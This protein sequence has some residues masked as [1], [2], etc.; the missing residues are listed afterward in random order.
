MIIPLLWLSSCSSKPSETAENTTEETFESIVAAHH[1]LEQ[2]K[3]RA[4]A[5]R[6]AR[7]EVSC[8]LIDEAI[9]RNEESNSF[10]ERRSV[11]ALFDALEAC[12]GLPSIAMGHLCSVLL[13]EDFDLSS[14]SMA[15]GS[16]ICRDGA[17]GS[18]RTP[19][20]TE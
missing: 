15:D 12:I 6:E 8:R 14:V 10:L 13:W 7:A 19:M 16:E 11:D 1:S 2:L 3:G 4:R 9:G 17:S 5:K 20:L 18:L